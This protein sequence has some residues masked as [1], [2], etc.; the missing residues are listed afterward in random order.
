MCAELSS[1]H[2]TL[3]PVWWPVERW[4]PSALNMTLCFVLRYVNNRIL[5]ELFGHWSSTTQYRVITHSGCVL[6]EPYNYAPATFLKREVS[7]KGKSAWKGSPLKRQ[8]SSKGNRELFVPQPSQA[9]LVH[10]C[11]DQDLWDR[12]T[13]VCVSVFVHEGRCLCLGLHTTVYILHSMFLALNLHT[14]TLAPCTQ[15]AHLHTCTHTC[16]N[17]T[18]PYS[19]TM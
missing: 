3:Q 12:S 11:F 6:I 19:G 5:Q 15:L 9:H 14:C 1:A 10:S 18:A 16:L 4:E 2:V 7:L 13:L 8:F 17:L